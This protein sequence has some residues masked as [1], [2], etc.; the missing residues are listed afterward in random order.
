[1]RQLISI[2]GLC[3]LASSVALAQGGRGGRQGGPGGEPVPFAPMCY[4][5]GDAAIRITDGVANVNGVNVATE[6][7]VL[8]GKPGVQNL[9]HPCPVGFGTTDPF[10]T[11]FFSTDL[12]MAHQQAIGLSDA[13]RTAIRT[14]TI[15]AQKRFVPIQFKIAAE[16]ETLQNLINAPS[17]DENATLDAMDRVLVL[18]RDVKREQV[19]LMI[20]VKN[21]LSQQQQDA[22]ARLRPH[23]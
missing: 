2:A 10:A 14:L 12:I 20:R 23:D 3:A 15:D 19:T 17:V 6:E 7:V 4:N 1:M 22:L 18:E 16:V 21:L 8:T 9:L 13:Q 11:S 5:R